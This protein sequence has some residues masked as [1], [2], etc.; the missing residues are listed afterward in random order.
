MAQAVIFHARSGKSFLFRLH[1]ALKFISLLAISITG[2]FLPLYPLAVIFALLVIVAVSIRLPFA[3]MKNSM[4]FFILLALL[5][6]IT[7]YWD[8]GDVMLSL[9]PVLRFTNVLM[10]SLILTDTTM[11]SDMARGLGS[12][13]SPLFGKL[14]WKF[15]SAVELT[16]AMLPLITDTVLGVYE[17][18]IS[19]GERMARHPVR[20]L[21]GFSTTTIST[22]LDRVVDYADALAS[23]E[24]DNTR[25]RR[26]YRGFH[27]EELLTVL[28]LLLLIGV[29]V[30]TRRV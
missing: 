7:E 12:F 16:M 25:K 6:F 22:L 26:L 21:V 2:G 17:A 3:L 24:Y 13:I 29:T 30:W 23:R 27:T 20:S 18:R 5:I 1:P 11:P 4:T 10:G 14:A 19:R 28:L 9:I 15:A 8:K